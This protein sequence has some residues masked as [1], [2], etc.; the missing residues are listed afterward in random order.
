[1]RGSP[2][3]THLWACIGDARGVSV[4]PPAIRQRPQR[5]ARPRQRRRP[6]SAIAAGPEEYGEFLARPAELVSVADQR[7]HEVAAPVLDR[8]DAGTGGLQSKL[9]LLSRRRSQGPPRT[10]HARSDRHALALCRRRRDDRA[11]PPSIRPTSN[12]R[13]AT[14]FAPA[15]RT[16]AAARPTWW[17]SIRNT[18]CRK[19]RRNTASGGS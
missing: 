7:H 12:G 16:C 6:Q 1:M 13:C 17:P 11:A 14:A 4:L 9:R 10:R 2:R 18:A 19:T 8:E 15:T 5:I 3:R